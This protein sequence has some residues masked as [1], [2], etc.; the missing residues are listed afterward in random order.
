MRQIIDA[1]RGR[2]S[3]EFWVWLSLAT[4]VA[5]GLRGYHLTKASFWVDELNTVRVCCDPGGMHKSKVF[6]YLPT[7]I[8]LSLAGAEPPELNVEHPEL[9]QELGVTEWSTRW[10]SALIGA[11][12]IPILGI[13][14]RRMLGGRAAGICAMLLAIAPYHIFWSQ[15][16]RFYTQQFLFYQLALIWYFT[17]TERSSRRWF[18]GSMVAIGLTFL[19][20]PTGLVICCVLAVDWLIGNAR[21]KPIKLGWF[22]WVAGTLVVLGCL[23][24]LRS[25]YDVKSDLKKFV[26]SQY[27]TPIPFIL[28][29]VFFI[30]P[31]TAAFSTISAWALRTDHTR[32]TIF[33]AAAAVVPMLAFAIVSM[34]MY[35]GL[36]YGFICL[37]GWLALSALGIERVYDVLRPRFGRLMAISPM[38]LLAASMMFFNFGYYT[39]GRGFHARWRD[40]FRYID[41][42]RKK[43]G[44]RVVC[45]NARIGQYYLQ[46]PDVGITPPTP[47]KLAEYDVP[48]WIAV[49]VE[50]AVRGRVAGW[51]NESAEWKAQFDCRVLQP[52]SS[53]RV[54]YYDPDRKRTTSR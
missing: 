2:D 27:Q 53:V 32:R 14:S 38:L 50:D 30:G 17:A 46:D 35:V 43:P 44:D 11:L 49:E 4:I 24:V 10:P 18:A 9:W 54:Y 28:G 8:G 13:V 26:N 31:V 23:Y 52:F 16:A 48:V 39:E 7:A 41:E 5:F 29:T 19:S 42:N 21:L 20:Q 34:R 12:S 36:R 6:G 37:F 47:E 40:A 45:H 33:L 51:I 25:D 3:L 22:G 1:E 15:A